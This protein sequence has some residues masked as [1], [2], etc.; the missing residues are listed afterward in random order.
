MV[1]PILEHF[2]ASLFLFI[3]SSFI[4]LNANTE[5]AL[6]RLAWIGVTEQ[7]Y[8][9]TYLDSMI[10][11]LP[12]Y[13]LSN[14]LRYTRLPIAFCSYQVAPTKYAQAIL[15]A[16]WNAYA[17]KVFRSFDSPHRFALAAKID[18]PNDQISNGTFPKINC[19]TSRKLIRWIIRVNFYGLFNLAANHV[20]VSRSCID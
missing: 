1:C 10:P 12:Q 6:T 3:F 13:L 15:R 18:C 19:I 4:Q 8:F 17:Y 20:N 11:T 14:P 7:V 9:S 2:F 5:P 16:M